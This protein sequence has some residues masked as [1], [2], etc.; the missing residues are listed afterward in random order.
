MT[1]TEPP[2][3]LRATGYGLIGVGAV[4]AVL[5][6][7]SLGW[8]GPSDETAA[9]QQESG[10]IATPDPSTEAPQAPGSDSQPPASSGDT[11]ES[12]LAA[13][14]P[15]AQDPSAQDPS[16]QDPGSAEPNRSGTPPRESRAPGGNPESDG[17]GSG[18]QGSE[19]GIS[20]RILN[21]STIR[22]LAH[23]AGEDFEAKG[24][25]VADV[26]NYARGVVSHTTAY[27]H[28]GTPEE[29]QARRVA[30]DFGVRAEPR[31]EELEGGDPGVIVVVTKDY[32]S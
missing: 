23:E 1:P 29:Q 26:G 15:S 10:A 4:A 6:V 17:S 21:N 31:I 14:D 8:S 19:N 2:S 11:A 7:T 30:D 32:R 12:D 24:Y 16:A 5:G 9:P 20:V 3:K 28:P 13:P 25:D 18:T 27:Y 22:G